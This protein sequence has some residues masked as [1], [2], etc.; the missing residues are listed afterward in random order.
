MRVTLVPST[1]LVNLLRG[2]SEILNCELQ[3][4]PLF[5][6]WQYGK[7]YGGDWLTDRNIKAP[8]MMLAAVTA[9]MV[10]IV[11]TG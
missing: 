10:R 2:K 7:A 9:A 4:P 5:G 8:V 3:V 6:I 11:R 1:G